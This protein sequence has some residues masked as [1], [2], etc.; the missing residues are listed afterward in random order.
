MADRQCRPS[1]HAGR[2]VAAPGAAMAHCVFLGSR[3][4]RPAMTVRERGGVARRSA[5]RRRELTANTVNSP[6]AV[7]LRSSARRA[8]RRP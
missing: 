2:S 8:A 7:D 3:D 4:L 6:R 5:R 1:M